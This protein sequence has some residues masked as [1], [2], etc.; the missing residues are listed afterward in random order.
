MDT[1]ISELRKI[2]NRLIGISLIVIGIGWVSFQIIG[3]DLSQSFGTYLTMVVYGSAGIGS[4]HIIFGIFL[5]GYEQTGRSFSSLESVLIGGIGLV[6]SSGVLL[7][8]EFMQRGVVDV[9]VLASFP[10]FINYVAIW[11][12]PLGYVTT[13]RHRLYIYGALCAVP[14]AI[15]VSIPV[16]L[17]TG[18]GWIV[19]VAMISIP[20]VLALIPLMLLLAAPLLIAG[21]CVH[22]PRFAATE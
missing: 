2:D 12:F 10:S 21:R 17:L 13:R 3:T 8:W 16:L 7:Y 15:L 14:L 19:L 11:G 4:I 9:Q 20:V 22:S 6:V 18:G 5:L 1:Y